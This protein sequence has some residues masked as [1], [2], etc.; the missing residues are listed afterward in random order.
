M[1]AD[2]NALQASNDGTLFISGF[3]TSLSVRHN[4]LLVR[5]GEGRSIQQARFPR[6]NR[7]RLK[8]LVV[9]GKGG[10]MTFEALALLDQIGCS[11]A[12][13]TRD[14]SLVAASAGVAS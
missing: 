3:A 5:S 10:Y 7:P 4:Q 11:F 9:Y 14:G 6:A 2:G 8:R 12:N 1:Q 13:I